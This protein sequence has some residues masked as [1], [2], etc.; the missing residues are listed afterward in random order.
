MV[1]RLPAF[2]P[3]FLASSVLLHRDIAVERSAHKFACTG[4]Q[5]RNQLDFPTVFQTPPQS[6]AL[7]LLCRLISSD[8]YHFLQTV[9]KVLGDVFTIPPTIVVMS[10]NLCKRI[11]K[12]VHFLRKQID[13]PSHFEQVC[14]NLFYDC[15]CAMYNCASR[16]QGCL[17]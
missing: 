10:S 1:L 9:V 16:T 14:T 2:V 4:L 15:N 7:H 13:P 17:Y 11:P 12:F 8:L 5:V 6:K 3:N